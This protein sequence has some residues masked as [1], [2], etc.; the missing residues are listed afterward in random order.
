MAVKVRYKQGTKQQY[1]AL[2][3]RLSNAL[4]WC[5][6]TRELFKGDQL[7]SDG[8]RLGMPLTRP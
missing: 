3:E 1:L 4:Y 5:T 6:D 8:V 2:P 7:Y